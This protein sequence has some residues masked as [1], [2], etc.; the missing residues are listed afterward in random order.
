MSMSFLACALVLLGGFLGGCA[1]YFVSGLIGR[2]VGETFPWGTLVVNASGALIIGA[3]AALLPTLGPDEAVELIQ[4]FA[5]VG[6]LG[7]Y[8]TVSSFSLQ[9]MNLVLGGEYRQAVFNAVAS[10][11]FCVVSVGLGYWIIVQFVAG[12][13]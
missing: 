2:W 8:T 7:G 5:M 13:G 1:R 12:A 10:A 6:V 11:G 4:D 9:T 3:I